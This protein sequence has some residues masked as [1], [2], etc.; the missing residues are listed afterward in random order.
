M[1]PFTYEPT[2]HKL[3]H[4]RNSFVFKRTNVQVSYATE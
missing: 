1:E 2:Q 3:C 4:N